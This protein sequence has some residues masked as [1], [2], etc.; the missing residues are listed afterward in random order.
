LGLICAGLCTLWSALAWAQTQD[1]PTEGR[2]SDTLRPVEY[3][4]NGSDWIEVTRE[5]AAVGLTRLTLRGGGHVYHAQLDAHA[6]VQLARGVEVDAVL[7]SERLQLVRQLSA[8]ARLYLVRGAGEDGLQL[9]SR[10]ATAQGISEAVPDLHLPRARHAIDIPPDDPHYPGQWYLKKISIEKAWKHSTGD[11]DTKVVVIDDGCDMQ[12]PDLREQFEGGFDALDEDDDASFEPGVKNNGH[13]TMCAGLV[14]ARTNN[15]EGMAGVCPDCSMLCVRLLPGTE[16]TGVPLSADVNAFQYAFDQGASVVSNSWGF[17]ESQPA[18]APLRAM[19]EM[20][21]DE[22][23][24]GAG[25]L[26]VFAAGNENRTISSNE[27]AAVRGVLAVGAINNFDEAAA[28][29]N[30]GTSLGV[31]SPAGTFTTDISGPDGL[32]DGDYTNLFGGTSSACPV[33]AG[34]AGLVLSARKDMSADDVRELLQQTAR[35]APFAEPD[36]SGHDQT[37]GYGIV[38]PGAALRSALGVEEEPE[39]EADAGAKPND[40]KPQEASE[41]SGC[42]VSGARANALSSVLLGLSLWAW[43]RRRACG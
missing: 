22:G 32:E 36:S 23:R 37:Y 7:R 20:L 8:A 12:H 33:V 34:V 13:G 5:E 28:F 1:G 10:L 38:D 40:D 29:S 4:R 39:P 9:A 6:I 42:A 35:K 18:P 25:T 2:R 17:S 21:N 16:D 14:A 11:R 30:R 19:L 27:L 24:D 43:R 31:T 15:G 41:D 3:F 26:V